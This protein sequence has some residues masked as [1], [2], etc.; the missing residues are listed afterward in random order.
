MDEKVIIINSTNHF[1]KGDIA[2][3]T[4]EII[5]LLDI[6]TNHPNENSA[7][8]CCDGKNYSYITMFDLCAH[9]RKSYEID[10]NTIMKRYNVSAQDIRSKNY[11]SL[12]FPQ[13]SDENIDSDS[14][15]KFEDDKTNI[16]GVNI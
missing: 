14:E 15:T 9:I 2:N 3:N 5:K 7:I 12:I 16:E 10:L 8:I 11:A 13:K 4:G 6:L 1:K